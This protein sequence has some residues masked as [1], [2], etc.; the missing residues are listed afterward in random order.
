MKRIISFIISLSLIFSLFAFTPILANAAPAMTGSGTQAD[1]YIVTLGAQLEG[2]KLDGYYKLNNDIVLEKTIDGATKG[3]TVYIDGN[4]KTVTLKIVDAG[5]VGGGF[6]GVAYQTSTL[7]VKNF[8]LTGS[9]NCSSQG[10]A[11][12]VGYAHEG[13]TVTLENIVSTVNVTNTNAYKEAYGTGGLIG[14]ARGTDVTISNC[15]NIGNVTAQTRTGGIIGNVTANKASDIEINGSANLGDVTSNGYEASGLVTSSGK[16]GVT[17]NV[18]IDGCYNAGYISGGS[19]AATCNFVGEGEYVTNETKISNC[20]NAKT[21]D[22]SKTSATYF[23]RAK[24]NVKIENCYNAGNID[25]FTVDDT[26][27]LTNCYYLE[28]SMT[29]ASSKAIS[30]TDSQLK[31]NDM[32]TTLGNKWEIVTLDTLDF[33]PYPQLKSNTLYMDYK[34][35]TPYNEEYTSN[36]SD[37]KGTVSNLS[38]WEKE[39]NAKDNTSIFKVSK[40]GYC[41]SSLYSYPGLLGTTIVKTTDEKEDIIIDESAEIY[42]ATEDKLNIAGF[43]PLADTDFLALKCGKKFYLSSKIVTVEE[44]KTETVKLSDIEE[45]TG[46]F[47]VFVKW[48]DNV[49]VSI[50][51]PENA[52][53]KLNNLDITEDSELAFA[54]GA[55]YTLTVTPDTNYYIESIKINDDLKSNGSMNEVELSGKFETDTTTIEIM[56]SKYEIDN[57]DILNDRETNNGIVTQKIKATGN[58]KEFMKTKQ[59]V[60]TLSDSLNP[61][62]TPEVATAD[63]NQDGSFEAVIST[64]FDDTVANVSITVDGYNVILPEDKKTVEIYPLAVVNSFIEKLNDKNNAQTP[65][66][67]EDLVYDILNTTAL[68]FDID[69]F[70]ILTKS[71]QLKIADDILHYNGTYDIAIVD[72]LYLES[73]I[74]TSFNSQTNKEVIIKAISEYKDNANLNLTLEPMYLVYDASEDKDDIYNLMLNK[75]VVNYDD[76]KELFKVAVALSKLRNL[77]NFSNVLSEL[78]TY[79]TVLEIGDSQ[80]ENLLTNFSNMTDGKIRAASKYILNNISTAVDKAKLYS[81]VNYA[82]TNAQ[83]LYDAEMKQNIVVSGGGGG[84]TPSKI[85]ISKN[86]DEDTANEKDS[87]PEIIEPVSQFSDLNNV[88]WAGEAINELFKKGILQ[89]REIGKFYPQDNITRAEFVKIV[90]T[91]FN[92]YD[93]NATASFTDVKENDW[94]YKYIASAL[95]EG[96]ANGK[97]VTYF[98]ADENITREE[99][100]VMLTGVIYRLSL[101]EE[102]EERMSSETKFTDASQISHFALQAVTILNSEGLLNGYEDGTFKPKN[103][104]TRAEATYLIYSVYKYLIK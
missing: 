93:E 71:E 89:G 3:K 37:K 23:V 99:M 32:L 102:M 77:D 100:A 85:E 5:T 56:V 29:N 57:F 59:V 103:N 81:L 88:A 42:L 69:V 75:T 17:H 38:N 60:F 47:T 49:A 66:T 76:I 28:N 9:I 26:L 92:L 58:A 7:T 18:I 44:R 30:V 70:K 50:N 87:Q 39:D 61:Q 74:K 24:V 78:N 53:V 95:K 8:T 31:S 10:V 48:L 67:N 64:Q 55:S 91:L 54:N 12:V 90:V 34:K 51:K 15:K 25:Y 97:S 4:N 52:T 83:E 19:S 65:Y 45:L 96:V 21:E 1:P 86:S 46:K 6:L 84:G 82:V 36:L 73:V 104:S 11:A 79:K 101:H 20:Y 14:V 41:I 94:S 27:N 63:V 68:N 80:F 33:Y 35:F 72:G 62:A 40:A 43:T 98:G 2:L 16:S 22:L 13:T